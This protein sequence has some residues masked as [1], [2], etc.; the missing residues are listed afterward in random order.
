MNKRQLKLLVPL[1]LS[2][3]AAVTTL[4]A[5]NTGD[6]QIQEP[7]DRNSE[8][9]TNTWSVYVQSGLSWATDVWYQNLDATRS[10][11]QSPALGGSMS[12]TIILD[13]YT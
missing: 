13:S 4:K 7:R 9:R 11:S 1:V 3:I 6:F 12:H 8:L 2:C 10:Y 5:Q